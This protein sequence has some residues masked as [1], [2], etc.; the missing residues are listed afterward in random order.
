MRIC[1]ILCCLFLANQSKAQ[2]MGCGRYSF[3][4]VLRQSPDQANSFYYAVLEETQSALKLKVGE[5]SD[6][7]KLLPFKDKP[8][9]IEA[10]L[11]KKLN[12]TLG[13]INKISNIEMRLPNPLSKN[14]LGLSQ[15]EIANCID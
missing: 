8:T 15:L 2:F 13:E 4:G 10:S 3:K 1:F 11:P 12:G 14:S 6:L 7:E 9:M 5:G